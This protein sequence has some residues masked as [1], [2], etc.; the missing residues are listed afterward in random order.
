MK[1]LANKKLAARIG[2]L[3]L[4]QQGW[5][6]RV[7]QKVPDLAAQGEGGYVFLGG[8]NIV[9]NNGGS[10]LNTETT[11]PGYKEIIARIQADGSTQA[12]THSYRDEDGGKQLVVYKYL[13]DRGPR[14]QWS[15][16]GSRRPGGWSGRSCRSRPTVAN[17]STITTQIQTSTVRCGDATDLVRKATGYAAEADTKMEQLTEAT[18]NI[19]RSSA[20]IGTGD[21]PDAVLHQGDHLRL[22]D[23]GGGD[24]VHQLLDRLDAVVNHPHGGDGQ[25]GGLRPRF[26]VLDGASLGFLPGS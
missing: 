4:P 20:Q 26:H 5:V 22:L 3:G 17:V 21:L 1:F 11:D 19:D 6:L 25:V 13:K 10:G 9:V 14:R 8:D 7:V 23:A 16:A 24:L 18:Q 2:I 12:G 15:A